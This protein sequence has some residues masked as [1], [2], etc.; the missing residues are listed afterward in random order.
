MEIS[1]NLINTQT[2]LDP[3]Q[4]KGGEVKE[5]RSI[6]KNQP[7]NLTQDLGADVARGELRDLDRLVNKLLGE[8]KSNPSEA[9][10]AEIT[11]QAKS[12]QVSPNLVKDLKSIIA[13][14]SQTPELK[15]LADKLKAFLKPIAELKAGTLNEQIKGS[16]IML[17]ANLK[18]ALINKNIL[19]SSINKLFGDIKNIS[20]QNL[21]NQIL[22]LT[23]DESLSTNESFAKLTEILKNAKSQNSEILNASPIK[24]LLTDSSKLE[25]IVKFLDKQANSMSEKGL[26]LSEK[27][28][29]N[30]LGKI[31]ELV[32]N[33]KAK[34]PDIITEKLSQNRAFSSNL[35]ELSV[36]VKELEKSLEGIAKQQNVINSFAEQILNKTDA[37]GEN[38][39]LQDRLKSVAKKLNQALNLADKVGFEAK[40]NIVEID[41][42]G[43]QQILAQKDISN[44]QTKVVEESVKHLQN[45]VKSAL[46]NIQ[47]KSAPDS[48]VNQLSSKLLTQIEMHQLVS[49]VAGGMQTYLPYVWDAVE[50][51]NISFKQ[52]KKQKH[53]AQIDLNF[54]KFGAINITIGLSEDKYI[55]I[56]IATQK[57]EFK[58]LI[59]SG[60]KELKRAIGEQ[61]LIMSNF[62]LKTM[63]KLSLNSVYSGFDRLNMGFDRII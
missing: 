7:Q 63:P 1:K 49:S 32:S 29:K 54:Q 60:A 35:K 14:A 18:D 62:S 42:L 34:I 23:K 24:S 27:S 52:G 46:L 38:L 47:S 15:E 5:S 25:N 30:E 22:A 3:K 6:F 13:L 45:D 33:L 17:E 61:G 4:L 55:D 16:G 31:N 40:G 20:N 48:Q 8:L 56:S 37:G 9:K 41:R 43:K 2:G 44:I 53:Y 19:P 21:L 39:S 57:D 10:L 28:V 12:I 11:N 51:G 50:G 26:I 58:E 59:L 36:A